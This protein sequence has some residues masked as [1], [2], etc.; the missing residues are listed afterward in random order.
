MKDYDKYKESLYQYWDRN[1]LYSWAMSKKL[2]VYNFEWMEDTFQFNKDFIKNC[3]KE[4]YFL[5][6]DIQYIEKL[7]ELH[8][9]LPFLAERIKFGKVKKL[10]A[11]L[12][13]KTEYVIDT[14]NLKQ[15][16]NYGLILKKVRGVIKFN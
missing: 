5:K 1:N 14:R 2:S 11:N 7:C 3:N 6:F 9:D 16:S 13:D 4:R 15:A 8:N 12:H 10:V